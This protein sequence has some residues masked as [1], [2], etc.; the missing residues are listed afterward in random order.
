MQRSGSSGWLGT[1]GIERAIRNLGD[2]LGQSATGVAGDRRRES[3]TA[4]G[5]W[6]ESER[7]IVVTTPGNAGESE[8]ALPRWCFH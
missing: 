1:A 2:L 7:P 5:L 4:A 6:Q 8:G 3:I